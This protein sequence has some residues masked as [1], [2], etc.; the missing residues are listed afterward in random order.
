MVSQKQEQVPISIPS[1]PTL[2]TNSIFPNLTSFT[3]NEQHQ[4][5]S[6][7]DYFETETSNLSAIDH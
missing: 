4:L 2:P 3:I 1:V 6:Q 5:N 7:A